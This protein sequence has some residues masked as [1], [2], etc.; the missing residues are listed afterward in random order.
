MNK[1]D[2]STADTLRSAL[3]KL[4]VSVKQ[5][6]VYDLIAAARG[7]RNRELLK[8]PYTVPS[9]ADTKMLTAVAER[10]RPDAV[11]IIVDCAS[12]VAMPELL[13]CAVGEGRNADSFE[14]TFAEISD[15]TSFLHGPRAKDA[16]AVIARNMYHSAYYPDRSDNGLSL[17]HGNELA[18]TVLASPGPHDETLEEF[19]GEPRSSYDALDEH[20]DEIEAALSALERLADEV[21]AEFDEEEW[22]EPLQDAVRQHLEAED[23]SSVED[24]IQSGDRAELLFLFAPRGGC[25][26]DM[27]ITA[28]YRSSSAENVN[29]DHALQFALSRLGYTIGEFRRFSGNRKD[30][31]CDLDADLRPLPRALV[32]PGE[33]MEILD[34][35]GDSYFH[36]GLYVQ[37]PISDILA[38]EVNRPITLRNVHVCAHGPINGTHFDGPVIDEIVVRPEDGLLTAARY[39]PSDMCGYVNSYFY[40]NAKNV[41]AEAEPETD[42][43]APEK[44]QYPLPM[45][46]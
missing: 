24:M 36:L 27:M 4:G 19:Y 38:L 39:S 28:D 1:Q 25:M 42:E 29:I 11:E 13:D 41:E 10:M 18:T 7:L 12:A 23:D 15:P 40:G 14:I 35:G 33:L 5:T 9:F 20:E 26:G 44:E 2:Q 34:N 3:N 32:T 16:I 46:A 30:A 21:G 8:Q 17:K 22:R 6:Q 37:V 45:A 43:V 31:A